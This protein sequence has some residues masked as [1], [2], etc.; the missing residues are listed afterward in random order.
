MLSISLVAEELFK[1]GPFPVTNSL[2]TSWLSIIVIS[3]IAL[4]GLAKQSLV[5]RGLQLVLES[6]Y[7]F[8]LNLCETVLESKK[9]AEKALP[10]I[11]TIFIFVLANNFLG[12]IPGAGSVGFFKAETKA[13]AET[14]NPIQALPETNLYGYEEFIS[15][16]PET[17]N[18]VNPQTTEFF[19][20]AV[21]FSNE[22]QKPVEKEKELVPILRAGSADL[23][24]TLA[25]AIIS[26][27]VVQIVGFKTLGFGYLKKFFN[28]SNPVNFFVGILELISEFAKVVSF[29]FRLFGNIFAG[30]VLLAV[31]LMLVPYFV[32]I[33]FYGLEIFVAAIQAF[34]FAMLTLVFIKLATISHANENH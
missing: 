3:I 23:N 31:M 1:I 19:E 30:E 13:E 8:F 10:F 17:F 25:L 5:P 32:P 24:M 21:P 16:T 6:I 22:A 28:F 14:T 34:V 33:P 20:A 15:E 9:L 26:M 11:A 29:A 7:G 12:L 27:V 2:L 4:I 18:S